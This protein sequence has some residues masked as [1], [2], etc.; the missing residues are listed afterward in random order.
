MKLYYPTSSAVTTDE[1]IFKFEKSYQGSG[2]TCALKLTDDGLKVT[3]CG[4]AVGVSFI[5]LRWDFKIDGD[6]KAHGGAWERTYKDAEWIP[7]KA[8]VKK[9]WYIA[10]SNG[11]DSDDDTQGR[12]TQCFGVKVRPA[13]M[14]TFAVSESGISL[15]LDVRSGAAPVTLLGREIEVCTVVS[16]EYEN[17]Y[18]FDALASFMKVISPDPILPD[19]VVYGS[20][21]WY[22]AYGRSSHGEILNDSRLVSMMTEGCKNRPYMVIDD[23]WQPNSC[24][25]P[26]DRGNERFPDMKK[27][28]DEMRAAGVRPGIWVRYLV[29]GRNNEERKMTDLPEET[30][31]SRH[32]RSLDPSHPDVIEYVR[33]TTKR[34]TEWGYELIKHD[35][36]TFDIF[37]KWA[38]ETDGDMADGEWGFYDR[39]KTTAEVIVNLYK[40][41]KEAAGSA[42]I[43]GCNT[44]PHLCAG[45]A[46]IARTGD[47]TSGYEW[48]RTRD[49]GVNTLAFCLYQNGA[50]YATDA[51]CVG[52]LK[53]IPWEK[54]REWLKLVALSASPLFVSCKPGVLSDGEMSELMR[55][56]KIASERKNGLRPIDWMETK[57]PRLYE[58]DGE[59]IEFNW[60]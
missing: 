32:N 17:I 13:A 42:I 19:H 38:F 16:R 31:L 55:Y 12:L 57:T 54:N 11:S 27:L 60:D 22:Y 40:A 58:I 36:S 47:D 15:K 50:Y 6:L 9:P 10:V 59:K 43:L 45:L 29:N 48:E 56:M 41:I 25:A 34:L 37:G 52:I 39:T 33:T 28:S 7:V 21:N 46:E 35:F 18:A 23:G 51:D 20:N 53:G 2:I 3:L 8:G 44:V 30:Y 26:W 24:D 5:D 49:Y 14:A 4:G 1:G